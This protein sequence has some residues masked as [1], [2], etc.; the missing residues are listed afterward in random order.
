MNR[1]ELIN[2]YNNIN[3]ELTIIIER[4][5]WKCFAT[6]EEVSELYADMAH[7]LLQYI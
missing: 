2:G 5:R 4:Y 6:I 3:K 7:L 1:E